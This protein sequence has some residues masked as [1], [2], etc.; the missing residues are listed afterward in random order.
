[1]DWR[2]A[3]CLLTLASQWAKAHPGASKP[4]F[5]GDAAHASRTSDHN[6]WVVD[7]G[8]PNVVTA[9]DIY[10][11]P[12]V[13]ADAY[14]LAEELKQRKDPRV[15]YVISRGKIWS[16]ARDSEG[17]R[18]YKGDPHTGHT[19]VS[20]SPVKSLYDNRR[21]WLLPGAATPE[22]D[23]VISKEQMAELKKAADDS[24]RKWALWQVLFGLQTED[25]LEAARADWREAYD[26]ARAAGKSE[27]QAEAAGAAAAAA[28]LR[29]LTDAIKKDQKS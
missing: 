12:K 3:G 2:P 17:W 13:G 25:D 11:Q 7:P 27:V 24:A 26:A 5:I 16:L 21:P 10:H 28:Q 9:G 18:P 15:K 23:D 1:M 8:G 22:G 14:A 6:P 4:G 20:V 29:T 19:H